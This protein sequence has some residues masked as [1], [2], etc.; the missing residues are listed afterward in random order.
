MLPC[1]DVVHIVSLHPTLGVRAVQVRQPCT[2]PLASGQPF[3]FTNP[4]YI[5]TLLNPNSAL[6]GKPI[7]V[8][9]VGKRTVIM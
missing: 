4:T 3:S 1:P 2:Q 8:T 5:L 7:A 9:G 6:M